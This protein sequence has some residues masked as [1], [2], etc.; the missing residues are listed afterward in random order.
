M[1]GS[2]TPAGTLAYDCGRRRVI[3]TKCRPRLDEITFDYNFSSIDKEVKSLLRGAALRSG[4]ARK[5][6]FVCGSLRLGF[7]KAI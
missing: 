1:R 5:P 3:E 4:S 7:G 6:N 2:F